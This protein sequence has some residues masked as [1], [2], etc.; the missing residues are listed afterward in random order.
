MGGGIRGKRGSAWSSRY[1]ARKNLRQ[2]ELSQY[3]DKQ[4]KPRV[5]ISFHIEDEA[6]VNLLRYQ[7]KNSDKMEFTDYSVKEPFD[8]KWK[9]RCI[10]R[11]KQSSVVVVA[12]GEE[13]HKREAVLWEIRKAHELGKPVIGMRIRSDKNHKIPQL[14]LDHGDKVLPWKLDALQAELERTQST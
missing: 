9:T 11:I 5:F 8:E 13:T 3:H 12:I 7:S 14:M 1:N 2:K 4:R 10:E 6:Q